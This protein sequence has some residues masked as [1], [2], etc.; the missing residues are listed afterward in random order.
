MVR[1]DEGPA[2]IFIFD[3]SD[4]IRNIGRLAETERRVQPGVRH[5]DDDVGRRGMNG[6]KGFSRPYARL[7]NPD[8]ID[9]RVG[10]RKIDVFKNAEAL[11]LFPAMLSS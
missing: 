3:E 9:D 5:A 1:R 11:R 6:G 2:D 4:P 7:M 10:P 8:A